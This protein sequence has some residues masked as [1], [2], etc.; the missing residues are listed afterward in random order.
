M[1][2]KPTIATDHVARKRVRFKKE[3]LEVALG[4]LAE[5]GV[6]K[7]TLAT[8]TR[9]LGLSKPAIYHY[10]RSKEELLY[11]LV[12]ELLHR[13]TLALIGAVSTAAGR[14]QVLGVL[15]RGYYDHYRPRLHAF[16]LVYCQFQLLDP[17]S[18]GFDPRT[19][20]E[21]VNPLSRGLFDVVES[22][23][24]ERGR[25]PEAVQTRRLAFSAWLAAVGL[26]EMIAMSDASR[27][28]LRHSDEDLLLTLEEVFNAAAARLG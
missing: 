10:F 22:I 7:L 13:E 21:D 14:D 3:I 6:D 8:L 5:K 4:L 23:M 9:R 25:R 16:R 20:R 19:M 11:A 15:I 27:D 1:T 12:L 26:M 24:S 17:P 18:L 28:P 2:D